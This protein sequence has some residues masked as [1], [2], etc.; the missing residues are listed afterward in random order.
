MKFLVDVKE[1]YASSIVVEA[2]SA[3]EAEKIAMTL[4]ILYEM[5]EDNKGYYL[6]KKQQAEEAEAAYLQSLAIA[7]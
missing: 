6:S 2:D 1:I 4:C 3:E 5:D 7:G